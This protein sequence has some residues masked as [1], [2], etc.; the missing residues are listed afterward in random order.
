MQ[1]VKNSRLAWVALALF[2]VLPAGNL[3]GM[4]DHYLSWSL[5]SGGVPRA[6][7][8]GEPTLLETLS[9]AT[10][11]GRLTFI[12]WTMTE[13]N[14]VPYPETRVFAAVFSSLCE[15]FDHDPSLALFVIENHLR[16]T[17]DQPPT[18][19]CNEVA[20]SN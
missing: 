4:V 12:D 7:L 8:V 14:V 2:W 10:V 13:M 16:A 3:F 11:D 9:P 19:V 15:R 17:A 1:R 20:T 18:L 5:Y 6:V